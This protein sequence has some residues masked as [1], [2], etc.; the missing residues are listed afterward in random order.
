MANL[1]SGLILTLSLLEVALSDDGLPIASHTMFPKGFMFGASTAAYQVEGGWNADGKGVSIWDDL[2]HKYP[3]YVVY[4]MN[5]DVSDDSYHFYKDDVRVL[6]E[7]GFQTY[8]F[9]I[10]WPRVL[11]DGTTSNI[12]QAG[13]DYYMNLID[14]LIANGIEPVVAL[15]HWDLP[16]TL[17]KFGGWLNPKVVDLFVDYADLMFKT[18][19]DKVKWWI[20]IN[21]PESVAGGYGGGDAAP[22]L[23]LFG[24]GDYLSGHNLLRAHGK[25]YRLYQKKYSHFGGKISMAFC[26]ATCYPASDSPEDIAA[27][28]RCFQFSFG[29]FAHPVIKGDYPP[30]MREY[31]DE[32][33][34]AEG[35]DVSRLP[36]FTEEEIQ[37]INGTVDW[38]GLNYY[39][40]QM[41]KAGLTDMDPSLNRDSRIIKSFNSSWPTSGTNWLRVVPQGLRLIAT[42]VKEAYGDIPI[43][44]TENGYPDHG[45]HDD[46]RIGYFET[47]LAELRRAIYEDGC[48]IFGICIWSIIDNFEWRNGYTVKFGVVNVDF[49]SPNR[50]RTLKN[51][52]YWFQHYI[53]MH[54]LVE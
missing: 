7:I 22:A 11:P 16:V 2:L 52:G 44:V 5:G 46:L 49:N 43:M 30:V 28:D 14:E 36:Y 26:G 41:V 12:N 51:S 39:T 32:N 13:I 25:T 29:W 35:R 9:S 47:H 24:T 53:A 23:N 6:K 33:S 19:G 15:Y 38:F 10:A 4:N 17:Q 1:I 48:N 42:K 40:S 34:M 50:T 8:R 37:E 21:E 27:V 54:K 18:Y 45:E 20:T 31:V 3:E